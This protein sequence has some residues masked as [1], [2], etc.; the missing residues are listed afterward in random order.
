MENISYTT[1]QMI[2]TGIIAT[3]GAAMITS[4]IYTR[5]ITTL[6]LR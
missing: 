3:F 6:F 5:N 2:I 4:K 1:S